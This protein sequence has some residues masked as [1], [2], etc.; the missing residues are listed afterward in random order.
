MGLGRGRGVSYPR[1]MIASILTERLRVD[2]GTADWRRSQLERAGYSAEQAAELAQR[3][4]IDLH[5]A[6]ELLER[7]CPV[8][9]ALA[10]LL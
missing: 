1:A 7:G 6:A 8:E 3:G 2:E 10:I 4:E 9:T 5:L